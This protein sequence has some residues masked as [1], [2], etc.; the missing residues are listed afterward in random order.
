MCVDPATSCRV[1][2][3][4][5]ASRAS[6]PGPFPPGAP[7]QCGCVSLAT[8]PLQARSS[9]RLAPSTQFKNFKRSRDGESKNCSQLIGSPNQDSR[10]SSETV[11]HDRREQLPTSWCPKHQHRRTESKTVENSSQ[12]PGSL[13]AK[14]PT[15]YSFDFPIM[16]QKIR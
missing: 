15:Y 4:S 10:T 1:F 5:S 16:L 3:S 8:V 14:S 12:L 11:E 7:V 13:Y 9:N 6:E 2:P